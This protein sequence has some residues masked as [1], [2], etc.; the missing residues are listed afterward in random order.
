MG[1][2]AEQLATELRANHES[3]Q[4]IIDEQEFPTGKI[5]VTVIWDQWDRT[6][7]E[8]RTAIILRAYEIAESPEYLSR[9]VLASGLTVPEA[10]ALGMLPY[11]IIPAL[12]RGDHVTADECRN[13]MVEE[14]ASILSDPTNP[15]LRFATEV[16]AE[17]S[18]KRL[19]DRLPQSEP[20]WVVTHEVGNVEDWLPTETG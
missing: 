11:Q 8:G 7:S 6:P 9:I 4:P 10:H 13:A 20:V 3:G 17:A 1:D 19:A 12:R 14:G 16:E 5:R 18:R 15:Q 2:L